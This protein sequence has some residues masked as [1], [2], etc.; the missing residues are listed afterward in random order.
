[1][2]SYPRGRAIILVNGDF[3]DKSAQRKGAQN[4][5]LNSE[6]ALKQLHFDVVRWNNFT[7]IVSTTSSSH[8]HY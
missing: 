6:R 2:E 8:Y 5:A 3:P 7:A 1:M 4:D